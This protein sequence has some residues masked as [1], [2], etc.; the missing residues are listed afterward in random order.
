[1]HPDDI[2]NLTARIGR[3]HL[4]RRL[5]L[6]ADHEVFVLNRPGA[7]FFYPE[8]W[9]SIHGFIR[10]ALRLSGLLAR[11]QHNAARLQVRHNRVVLPGLPAAFEGFKILHLSDLHLDMERG[12]TSKPCARGCRRLDA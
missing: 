2:D 7:H 10:H 4:R 9:Y 8:N 6:E 12:A 11:A 1:M 5:G 3:A